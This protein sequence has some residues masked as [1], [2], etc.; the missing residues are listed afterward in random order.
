VDSSNFEVI[1][2]GLRCTQGKCIA[3]SISL[4]AGK[5]ALRVLFSHLDMLFM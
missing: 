2:A 1:E 3:N 4:K 5:I